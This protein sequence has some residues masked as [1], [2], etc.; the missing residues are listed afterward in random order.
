MSA[1]QKS[2]SMNPKESS[3]SQRLPPP[4]PPLRA[5]SYSL[6]EWRFRAVNVSAKLL[7]GLSNA[8]LC[9]TH[10]SKQT[11]TYAQQTYTHTHTHT[12]TPNTHTSD[13]GPKIDNSNSMLQVQLKGVGRKVW[14]GGVR[15]KV[16]SYT[17]IVFS[18][19]LCKT[20]CK[21]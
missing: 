21:T 20:K 4:S 17:A 13:T 11:D 15:M 1:L 12:H 7:A 19:Y 8:S 18:K 3:R 16:L 6:K 5:F 14:G 2:I 9:R 10:A